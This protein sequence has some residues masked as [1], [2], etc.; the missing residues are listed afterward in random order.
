VYLDESHREVQGEASALL[1]E[2]RDRIRFVE[3]QLEAERQAHAEA[4]R[5]L[6]AALERI[7]PALEAPPE[8]RE[9]PVSRGRSETATKAAGDQQEPTEPREA[10][11]SAVTDE[12]AEEA[13]GGPGSGTARGS[14][15]R[16]MFGG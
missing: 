3:G 15:W 5:L 13:L 8:A 1:E 9:S 4:R 10:H 2:M 6:A 7:P 14:W 16:R 12:E 11:V